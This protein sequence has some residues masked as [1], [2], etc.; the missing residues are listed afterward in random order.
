MTGIGRLAVTLEKATDKSSSRMIT[1]VDEHLF[2]SSS[3][4][5]V[6]AGGVECA[7]RARFA[8][9]YRPGRALN[10]KATSPLFARH[11]E[12]D[13]QRVPNVAGLD[14][15]LNRLGGRPAV[16]TGQHVVCQ[17]RCAVSGAESQDH[18]LFELRQPH[19]SQDTG[20][21]NV[22]ITPQ[23][24]ALRGT[25]APDRRR[26]RCWPRLFRRPPGSRGTTAPR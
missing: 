1:T 24:P 15:I 18:P 14:T 5:R 8:A 11:V 16:E 19:V 3:T 4:R 2:D 26:P 12:V 9:I 22:P 21:A 13:A 7:L 6:C 20:P 10:P 25:P 17:H 23:G